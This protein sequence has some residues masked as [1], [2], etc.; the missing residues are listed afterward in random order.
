MRGSARIRSFRVEPRRGA[1]HALRRWIGARGGSGNLPP[2]PA[3]GAAR[4][5]F[6]GALRLVPQGL[7]G[8]RQSTSWHN[9]VVVYRQLGQPAAARQADQFSDSARQA[10]VFTL[11]HIQ[12]HDI[13]EIANALAIAPATVR[14]HLFQAT[15]ALRRRFD[16]K[17]ARRV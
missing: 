9:L 15:H 1:G 14:V 2:L 10:E 7:D 11:R 17:E 12:G 13:A 4:S 16:A 6:V 3:R 8:E 5:Q